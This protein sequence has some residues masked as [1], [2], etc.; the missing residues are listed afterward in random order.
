[1][2]KKDI[3]NTN[4]ADPTTKARKLPH[5]IALVIGA[6]GIVISLALLLLSC[7]FDRSE[8]LNRAILDRSLELGTQFMLNHQKPEGNFTYIYDWVEKTYDPGD[9]Q[10]RQAGAMWGLGM[11][12]NDTPNPGRSSGREGDGF[13]QNSKL[14]PDGHR[15]VSV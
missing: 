10:V 2:N 14:T 1:M 8:P 13:A 11:I 9:S 15:Y 4:N 3:M 6:T 5:R 7:N 12:Y